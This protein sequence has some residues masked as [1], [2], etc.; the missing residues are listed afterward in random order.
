[1]DNNLCSNDEI[2]IYLASC[3]G[4]HV[5]GNIMELDGIHIYGDQ[6]EYWTTHNIDDSNLVN[7]KP[8]Y[9]LKNQT[10]IIT[11]LGAGQV[12]LANCTNISIYD[13]NLTYS[14]SG[15]QLGFSSNNSITGNNISDTNN[16]IYLYSSHDNIISDNILFS[17]NYYGFYIKYSKGNNITESNVSYSGRG[18]YFSDSDE[19]RVTSNL[20]LSNGNVGVALV[21]SSNNSVTYNNLSYNGVGIGIDNMANQN[22]ITN[23][24]I[25]SN[26]Y[27]ISL[28]DSDENRIYHNDILI[29]TNQ[30]G[31][32][33]YGS[34]YWDNGYPA[35]GNFWS[36]YIGYDL[37]CSPMQDIPPPDGI[38]D[39][40]YIVDVDCQDN[41]PFMN[42]FGNWT[43][44]PDL[45]PPVISSV[46]ITGITESS[47][48]IIWET[49]EPSDSRVAWSI[50]PDL[51]DNSTEYDPVYITSHSITLTGLSAN[52][53]Y[54]FEV[55]SEDQNNNTATD[56]NGSLYYRFT[57]LPPDTTP[58]GIFSVTVS[59]ITL[60]SATI[61][62]I[63]D[64]LSDSMVNWSINPDLS[65]NSSIFDPELVKGHSIVLTSLN[66][67]QTYYFE[68]TSA[69]Q[70]NNIA[71]DNNGSFYYRFT[72]L[73]PDT[74]PPIISSVSVIDI[75]EI[76]ATITWI[77]NEPGTSRV[78]WSENPD[79]SNSSSK[80]E[81]TKSISHSI[82]LTSLEPSK[83]YYFLIISAD[84]YGNSAIDTNGSLFY[85]FTTLN[86]DTNPP[87]ITDISVDPSPQEVYYYTGI[88]VKVSDDRQVGNVS[89]VI[90]DPEDSMI[91]NFSMGY[92]TNEDRYY[93]IST[94]L[95][96][97]TYSFII[98]VNDTSNNWNSTQSTISQFIIHDTTPPIITPQSYHYV[99]ELMGNTNLSASVTDNF[100]IYIVHIQILDPDEIELINVTMVKE[101]A[102]NNY[103]YERIFNTLGN[104]KF[105]I[106]AKDKSDNWATVEGD[107][108]IRDTTPPLAKAGFDME[109]QQGET[110]SLDGGASADMDGIENFTWNF[111][112]DGE[113]V[114]LYGVDTDFRFEK[115]GNYSITLIVIDPSGNSANDM[116]WVNVI[117]V[118]FDSDGLTNYDEANIYGTN[119]NDPD[120]DKDGVNDGDEVLV[121]TDPLIP[122]KV[123]KSQ[124][125]FLEE[126]LWLVLLIITIIVILVIV[127]GMKSRGRKED[128][129]EELKEDYFSKIEEIKEPITQPPI[130]SKPHLPPPPPP[131]PDIKKPIQP[132]LPPPPPP[133]I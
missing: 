90:M 94:Y 105:M 8:V 129:K 131:P 97:G 44:P 60:N 15:I 4:A 107:I 111:E 89:V 52:Q 103:W 133:E 83:T 20:I 98:W 55:T 96:L 40:P 57:T 56:N 123:G 53:T 11:P 26:N 66:P 113:S 127:F 80:F 36:D 93:Y 63:T 91:G 124:R 132:P 3:K 17:N 117:G 74:I 18:I 67:D 92:D 39:T 121:G 54:Y 108:I 42:P 70:N 13:Q 38:G 102:T 61:T 99:Q 23:N 22:I 116:I 12:I 25:L 45:S 101:G 78:N 24:T 75:T 122:E 59:D 130:P 120:T 76:S 34:N 81:S 73:P 62:W 125:S 77:T 82:T 71:T 41:Y 68:V 51:S 95:K 21:G 32:G 115:V 104:Y 50:H 37:N 69:D 85:R 119:P 72:T 27:G 35:G 30:A 106:W 19:N 114:I 43:P 110:V 86:P 5:S 29:N 28:D 100:E 14:N 46:A 79:L 10:G 31:D 64:E 118:D 6:I 112:Y 49:D 84:V 2:G 58:P 88:W 126:Y 1:M 48:T 128:K 65:D 9:Y 7:G 47:A 16:G 87:T 33:S 109:I